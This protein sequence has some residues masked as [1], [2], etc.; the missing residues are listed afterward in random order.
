MYVD[1]PCALSYQD[2]LA[3][4]VAGASLSRTL[5]DYMQ[6][7]ANEELNYGR[8]SL[9]ALPRVRDPKPD[10]LTRCQAA[11]GPAVP[12]DTP[13][14]YPTQRRTQRATRTPVCLERRP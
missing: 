6:C 3:G 10:T 9:R 5:I 11:R 12:S 2:A 14:G 1:A 13:R 8:V 7:T 4:R